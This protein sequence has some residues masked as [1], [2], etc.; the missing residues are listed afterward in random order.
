MIFVTVGTDQHDFSRL[1]REMDKISSSVPGQVIAQIG[2]TK[3][4]PRG[5][6]WFRFADY[7][8]IDGLYGRAGIVITHAGAGSII[9]S[10]R[11]GNKTIVVPRRKMFGEHV[12][13]HQ[14]DLARH[15]G[16][17]KAVTVVYDIADL[18]SAIRHAKRR[19]YSKSGSIKEF[20]GNYIAMLQK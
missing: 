5:M 1:I 15:L 13:D 8:T 7:S 18:P 6:G 2:Y 12:N 14:V 10:L 3:Y 4:T 19:A 11:H 20:L 16:Q 17:R 9:N